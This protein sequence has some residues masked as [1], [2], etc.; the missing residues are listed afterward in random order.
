MGNE[1]LGNLHGFNNTKTEDG[2]IE[3]VYNNFTEGNLTSYLKKQ[4]NYLKISDKKISDKMNL[5][6]LEGTYIGNYVYP[7]NS[8]KRDR[9][10]SYR[11]YEMEDRFIPESIGGKGW[12][13]GNFNCLQI[14]NIEKPLNELKLGNHTGRKVFMQLIDLDKDEY[15]FIKDYDDK[16]KQLTLVIKNN[17]PLPELSVKKAIKELETSYKDLRDAIHDGMFQTEKRKKF[18][19]NRF[20]SYVSWSDG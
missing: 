20:D 6:E 4:E 16:I 11:I 19:I 1:I 12:E 14:L 10:Q 2:E 8:L 17:K 5:I 13:K 3:K 18:P 9:V 7:I 15:N